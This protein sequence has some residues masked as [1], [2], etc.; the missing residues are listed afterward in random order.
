M[1][2][3]HRNLFHTTVHRAIPIG[4]DGYLLPVPCANL[5]GALDIPSHWQL[6]NYMLYQ[7]IGVQGCLAYV[8]ET[9]GRLSRV[10]EDKAGTKAATMGWALL[11]FSTG[12]LPGSLF[13]KAIEAHLYYSLRR[14]PYWRFVNNPGCLSGGYLPGDQ[15]ANSYLEDCICSACNYLEQEGLVSSAGEIHGQQPRDGNY[16][17]TLYQDGHSY[18]ADAVINLRNRWQVLAGSYAKKRPYTRHDDHRPMRDWLI[19]QGI[20]QP[21]SPSLYRFAQSCEFNHP[22]TAAGVIAGQN[23]PGMQT[24]R[25]RGTGRPIRHCSL[26]DCLTGR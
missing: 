24:W 5:D 3:L 17:M 14:Q 15:P 10:L 6:H 2:I 7:N 11:L 4:N 12:T 23:V 18:Y 9:S 20:L 19:R 1:K 13:R 22:T 26:P 25:E 16:E 21:E 8:G